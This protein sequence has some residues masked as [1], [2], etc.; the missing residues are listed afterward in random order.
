MK[1]KRVLL[2]ASLLPLSACSLFTPSKANRS[3]S[4]DSPFTITL[5]N[6]KTHLAL[7]NKLDFEDPTESLAVPSKDLNSFYEFTFRDLPSAKVLDNEEFSYNIGSANQQDAYY[8]FKYTFYIRNTGNASACYE[9]KI[10]LIEQISEWGYLSDT[11]RVMVF[12]NDVTSINDE[13]SHEYSVFAKA[14][15]QYNYDK[16]GQRT[17]REFIAYS[18]VG[19]HEDDEHPLAE[20]FYSDS[21]ACQYGRYDMKPN[22]TIRYTVVFWLEGEDPQ[23][24]QTDEAPDNSS[25]KVK[26]D[27]DAYESHY[28]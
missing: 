9:L 12:E 27:V 20:T 13:S 26:I 25:L 6:N 15:E 17:D 2:F 11:I 7:S 28:F 22:D 16:D 5:K 14:A 23:S 8:Y 24:S 10:N 3:D 4:D 1:I 19:G 18:C 21:I